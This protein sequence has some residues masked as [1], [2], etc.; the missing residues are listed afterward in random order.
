MSD[1]DSLGGI[2]KAMR[3]LLAATLWSVALL[4]AAPDPR[5]AEPSAVWKDGWTIN[6]PGGSNWLADGTASSFYSPGAPSAPYTPGLARDPYAFADYA[7]GHTLPFGRDT[8]LGDMQATLGARV[9]EPLARNELSPAF[10]PRRYMG[11]GPRIGFEGNKPLQSSWIVEWR[12]GASVLY[13]DRT[14]DTGSGAANPLLPNTISSGSALNVDGLLGLSYWFDSA[15][16]L[17]VGYRADYF[18][19]S[20]TFNITATAADNAVNHG[21]LIR[22]SIQN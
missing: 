17:T 14:F 5:A 7:I 13:T 22:F 20:P 11:A 15:A 4:A 1:S 21:P 2:G 9:A 6:T 18:K 10:D 19:T 8:G 12:A 16:K 3:V